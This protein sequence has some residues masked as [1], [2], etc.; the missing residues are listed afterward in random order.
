MVV[1]NKKTNNRIVI[2][3][4]SYII[5]HTATITNKAINSAP[6]IAHRKSTAKSASVS[7]V[8]SLVMLKIIL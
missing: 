1:S 8:F 4:T 3:F 6:L 7:V 2:A 5:K